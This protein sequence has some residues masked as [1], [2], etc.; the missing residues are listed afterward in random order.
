MNWWWSLTCSV[1]G[2]K[3]KWQECTLAFNFPQVDGALDN[4]IKCGK[5]SDYIN[6]QKSGR[7]QD[8]QW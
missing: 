2:F 8:K 6:R 5:I 7:A 4:G 3:Y 1:L